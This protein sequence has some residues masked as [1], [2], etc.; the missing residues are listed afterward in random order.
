[1][2]SVYLKFQRVWVLGFLIG[3]CSCAIV[4]PEPQVADLSARLRTSTVRLVSIS[5]EGT[6]FSLGHQRSEFN[7]SVQNLNAG[8][9]FFVADDLIATNIHVVAGQRLISAQRVN[10][11]TVFRIKGVAAFDAANDIVILKVSGQGIG[12]PLSDRASVRVGM[13]VY[14]AGF[15]EQRYAFKRGILRQKQNGYH[16]LLIEHD[17]ADGSSGGPVLNRQGAIIGVTAGWDADPL[18]HYAIPSNVLKRLLTESD[19]IEP[20]TQWQQRD[21]IRAY[22]YQ[23]EGFKKTKAGD[24]TAIDDLN[25]A[26]EGNPKFLP[27]YANRAS[28]KLRLGDIARSR[29]DVTQAKKLYESAIVDYTTIGEVSDAYINRGSVKYRLAGIQSSSRKKQKLYESTIQ[30]WTEAIRLDSTN[31]LAYSNRGAL[32]FQIGAAKGDTAAAAEDYTQAIEDLTQAIKLD[33]ADSTAYFNR[34][35]VFG[36][37]GNPQA[38]IRDFDAAIARDPMYTKAYFERGLRKRD[39]GHLDAAAADFQKAKALDPQLNLPNLQRQ[40][41]Q[42]KDDRLEK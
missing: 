20:L 40:T 24:P 36:E 17:M 7:F 33:P 34:G 14:V 19:T 4:R 29:G 27:F 26:I 21:C 30:D 39:I 9:G 10:D 13:P 5:S 1:M 2:Y 38:A 16:W 41:T 18:Q 31:A 28:A 8:S 15:P 37:L 6:V 22:V 3:L 12:L 32:W 42:P 25:N 23:S 11:E 35:I